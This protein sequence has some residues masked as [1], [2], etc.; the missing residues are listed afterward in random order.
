MHEEDLEN[1]STINNQGIMVRL[2]R[3]LYC[4]IGTKTERQVNLPGT[5]LCQSLLED[6]EFIL[7]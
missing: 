1:I 6:S 7:D 4:N 5:L 3:R 2:S